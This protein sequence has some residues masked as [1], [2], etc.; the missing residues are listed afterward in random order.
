M[1][2]AMLAATVITNPDAPSTAERWKQWELSLAGPSDGNPFLDVQLGATFTLQDYSEPMATAL[3]IPLVALNFS[4]GGD[5]MHAPN[6]GKSNNLYPVA[7]LVSAERS[8]DV[9]AGR[10]GEKSLDFGTDVEQRH[11]A[12]L[13]GPGQVVET[14]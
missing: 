9:P 14:C 1:P 2:V 7:V 3:P 6:A 4:N 10:Q 8:G 13:P 12:E 5:Q 11:A